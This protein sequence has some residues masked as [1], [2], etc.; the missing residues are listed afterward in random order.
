MPAL[1]VLL[2]AGLLY[3]VLATKLDEDAKET[4][5]RVF[6]KSP[7]FLGLAIA[8]YSTQILIGSQRLRFLLAAQ[9]VKL[10][11]L[12]VLRLCYLGAFFDP[13]G[14]TSVGGDA[15]KAVYLA[16]ATPRGQRV[17]TVSVLV[18]DRLLGLLGLLTLTLV[19]A[20]W[21]IRE[22]SANEEVQPH[23]KWLFLAAA[24]LYVGTAMLL[25]K[26][27]YSCAP[28]QFAMHKMPL[29]SIFDRAFFSL[30]KYR[31]RP[32][33]LLLG[34]G[35]SLLV[36]LV[37]IGAGYFLVLGMRGLGEQ[38]ALGQ[39]LVAW[40]ISNFIC[41]FFPCQA[42]GFGQVLYNVIFQH[43]ACVPNGWVLATAAQAACTLAKLPGLAAWL[44]SRE[45]LSPEAGRG[46]S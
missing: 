44:A 1:K 35:M 29:G 42:V 6:L 11:Y 28:L 9:G 39:F 34:L 5:K 31:D 17:E 10:S 8:A 14:I 43:I 21:H 27:V 22:L 38:P 19:V 20:L 18:L 13:I 24:F 32:F 12:T 30:Q 37:G 45:H 36:H 33:T 25:S 40:L 23:L 3:Y 26:K 16:R 4:L 41:S 7:A 46:E 15:V 2:A